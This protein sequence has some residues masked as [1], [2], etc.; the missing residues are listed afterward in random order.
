VIQSALKFGLLS[1]RKIIFNKMNFPV[2][3]FP[4]PWLIDT[5][6]TNKATNE[7]K[8][9]TKTETKRDEKEKAELHAARERYL[10]LTQ[11]EAE[12]SD[13]KLKIRN[14]LADKYH[15]GDE[16]AKTV[17]VHG[18]KFAITRTLR[19]TITRE[20]AD[21]LRQEHPTEYAMVLRFTPEV[22]AGEYKKCA[23]VMDDYIVTK[24][25]PPSI[26]FK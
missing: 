4:P 13:E 6:L 1:S 15:D 26:E 12:A 9:I 24:P 18:I 11:I 16:G 7:M 14:Y 21:R 20:E 23:E 17:N 8:T 3:D 2:D 22:R 25:S 19:R 10:E 5:S